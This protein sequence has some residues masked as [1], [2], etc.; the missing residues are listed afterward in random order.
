[1][2]HITAPQLFPS[3]GKDLSM[4]N[5]ITF[6]TAALGFL[7]PQKIYNI[8]LVKP[9]TFR[10]ALSLLILLIQINT[11]QHPVFLMS[12]EQEESDCLRC[13]SVIIVTRQPHYPPHCHRNQQISSA[14][15]GVA[16]R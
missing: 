8:L 4:H 15:E 6:S 14:T 11:S 7:F 2:A 5:L 10:N 9:S 3:E 12:Y 13:A 16:D 1:M